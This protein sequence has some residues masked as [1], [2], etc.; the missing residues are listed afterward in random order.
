MGYIVRRCVENFY[1]DPTNFGK[2]FEGVKGLKRDMLKDGSNDDRGRSFIGRNAGDMEAAA[3]NKDRRY[4]EYANKFASFFAKGF[5]VKRMFEVLNA[6]DKPEY[7][8]VRKV[9]DDLFPL[10][11]KTFLSHDDSLLECL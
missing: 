7:I 3:R 9:C 6:E 1:S 10:L 8:G 11:K 4:L 5:L 2:D